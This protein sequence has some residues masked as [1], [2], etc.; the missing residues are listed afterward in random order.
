MRVETQFQR[1]SLEF[2]GRVAYATYPAAVILAGVGAA[3]A[4]RSGRVLR[5]VSVVL[6]ALAMA[7]GL[8]EWVQWR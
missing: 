6:L 8:R 3:W 2:V 7:A 5:V 1:Y 4:W